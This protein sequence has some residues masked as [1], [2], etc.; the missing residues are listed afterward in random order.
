MKDRRTYLVMGFYSSQ[1]LDASYVSATKY[2]SGRELLLGR[3]CCLYGDRSFI[4]NKP[5]RDMQF[6]GACPK[7]RSLRTPNCKGMTVPSQLARC[8]LRAT[9]FGMMAA[10]IDVMMSPDVDDTDAVIKASVN[11]LTWW[12]K[13]FLLEAVRC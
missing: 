1:S 4:L 7:V 8:A 13:I 9:T 12:Y 5:V 6:G 2:N 11:F 3:S 10:Y